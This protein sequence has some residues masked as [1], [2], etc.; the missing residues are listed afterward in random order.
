[1]RIIVNMA[2]F[3]SCEFSSSYQ[4]ENGSDGTIKY[5]F[6]NVWSTN[7]FLFRLLQGS[8]THYPLKEINSPC[9]HVQILI[10]LPSVRF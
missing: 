7:E 8:G 5:T 4:F 2:G 1:V 3:L 9:G 6:C 10:I